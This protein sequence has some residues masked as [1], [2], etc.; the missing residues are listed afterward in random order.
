MPD[1]DDT[2]GDGTELIPVTPTEQ[3][4]IESL[5]RIDTNV[6]NILSSYEFGPNIGDAL[7]TLKETTRKIF[8]SLTVIEGQ[9]SK[10]G[11]GIE[12]LL[13]GRSEKELEI[14]AKMIESSTEKGVEKGVRQ[15]LKKSEKKNGDKPTPT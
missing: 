7:T 11:A 4:I 6:Q 9:V 8:D 14:F 5:A 13:K 15:A 10:N 3:E 2:N 1:D 12:E